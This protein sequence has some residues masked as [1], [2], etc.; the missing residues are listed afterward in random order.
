MPIKGKKASRGKK[1]PRPAAPKR[2][3]IRDVVKGPTLRQIEDALA[4]G[5]K[6]SLRA[7]RKTI[8]W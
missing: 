2:R 4:S 3:T 7:F 8:G 5:T 6:E 1:A